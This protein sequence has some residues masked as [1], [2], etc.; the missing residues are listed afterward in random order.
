MTFIAIESG[1]PA[2]ALVIFERDCIIEYYENGAIEP[3]KVKTVKVI[4]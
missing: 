1:K 2:D 3:T 4:D